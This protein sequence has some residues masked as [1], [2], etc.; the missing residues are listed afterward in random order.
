MFCIL[1]NVPYVLVENFQ[2]LQCVLRLATVYISL[3]NAGEVSHLKWKHEFDCTP[4]L[5]TNRPLIDDLMNESVQM[6]Q[7][8]Q[9]W[10]DE[11]HTK[12]LRYS[13]LNHFTTRQLLFLRSKL[14]IVQGRGPRAVDGIP[15]EVYNLLESV[16]PGID[17]AT[18]KSVLTFCGICSQEDG[19]DIIRSY[20]T[21]S[22]RQRPSDN[23][24][25][26]KLSKELQPSNKEMFQ[27]L[28]AKLE[29][30]GYSEEVAIAAMIT[31]KDAT[32]ADLIVWSVQNGNNE[33]LI[34]AKHSEAQ[35]DPRYL[36]LMDKDSTTSREQER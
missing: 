19:Q 36:Q 33:D 34:S 15:L 6:E 31:C 17:L 28:V 9:L 3:C 24:H 22:K 35:N 1:I 10:K 16:L 30:L 29:L 2:I 32:E 27:S 4:R 12:R 21:S 20:G 8:L 7:F 13:E 25:R 26:S 14:A 5:A 11:L 23:S 18:L